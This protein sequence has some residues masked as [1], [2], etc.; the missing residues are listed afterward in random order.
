MT[1][2]SEPTSN[3]VPDSCQKRLCHPRLQLRGL[4]EI[5]SNFENSK[6]Y[7]YLQG[8][9]N[10]L[11][12]IIMILTPVRNVHVIQEFYLEKSTSFKEKST[13]FK[14]KS[15]FFKEKST[16]FREKS[17]SFKEKSTFFLSPRG[18]LIPAQGNYSL[19]PSVTKPF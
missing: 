19:R 10:H 1:L 18:A 6:A 3:D 7:H 13:S 9:R 2:D 15:T 12:A 16:S 4:T 11:D 17:T 5:Y 8:I 14:E